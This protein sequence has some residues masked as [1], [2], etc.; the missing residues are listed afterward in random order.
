MIVVNTGYITIHTPLTM[1]KTVAVNENTTDKLYEE[2][3]PL[4]GRVVNTR[5]FISR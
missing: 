5:M 2:T 1:E 4:R 3:F